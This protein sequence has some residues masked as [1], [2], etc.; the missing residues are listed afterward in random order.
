M[1]F[2]VPD[3]AAGAVVV[4]GVR[5]V[6]EPVGG[7]SLVEGQPD[8]GLPVD[9]AVAHEKDRVKAGDGDLRNVSHAVTEAA[10]PVVDVVVDVFE[11]EIISRG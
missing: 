9:V 5:E 7:A 1:Y 8:G 11:I 4:V 2:R 3:D 10:G 6:V